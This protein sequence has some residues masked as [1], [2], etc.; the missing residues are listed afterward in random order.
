VLLAV[1]AATS[2]QAG[3]TTVC[4]QKEAMQAEDEAARL[5]DWPA[6]YRS[7]TRFAQCDQGAIGEGYSDSIVRLL[8]QQWDQVAALQ[9]LTARD[10]RFE[11]FVLRHIDALMTREDLRL[12]AE[13]AQ[14]RCPSKA[15][16]LCRVIEGKLRLLQNRS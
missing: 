8:T 3:Q 15:K 16:R 4:T 9:R 13:N 5:P 12:I 11:Q 14:S 2:V 1:L 10:K 6:V 7:F